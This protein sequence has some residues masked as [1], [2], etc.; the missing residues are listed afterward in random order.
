MIPS[1]TVVALCADYSCDHRTDAPEI[2]IRTTIAQ[3]TGAN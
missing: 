2:T 1:F 3:I